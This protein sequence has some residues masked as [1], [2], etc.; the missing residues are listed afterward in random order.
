MIKIEKE[1]RRH[2]LVG[3][4]YPIKDALRSA[5]CKWDADRRA[6]WTG[7]ADVAE[8]LAGKAPEA[9]AAATSTPQDGT[10][11]VEDKV[12]RGRASYRGKT[13]YV[14]FDGP[15]R[16]GPGVKLC[17]RDGSRSFW[18]KDP[19]DV[20]V[21]ATYREP[22]SIASLQAYAQARAAGTVRYECDECGERVDPGTRC[23]E[24]GCIH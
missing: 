16:R 17:F 15:T 12:I 4:T 6:W 11:G 5:G 1:G 22:R 20:Q 14:L 13:Y 19:N 2:Y 9:S 7:K 8:E 10:V 18:A 24:T 3:N 23:W 21:L